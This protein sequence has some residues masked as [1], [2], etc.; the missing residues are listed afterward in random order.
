MTVDTGRGRLIGKKESSLT[1]D[2]IIGDRM[3]LTAQPSCPVTAN[4][5][6]RTWEKTCSWHAK[7][8]LFVSHPVV[9]DGTGPTAG[10][11][12][13]CA[14]GA[15]DVGPGLP[16]RGVSG[17]P[18]VSFPSHDTASALRPIQRSG[19]DERRVLAE[20]GGKHAADGAEPRGE[21]AGGGGGGSGR[22]GAIG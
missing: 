14:G 5:S 18:V 6:P 9:Y 7:H 2:K 21:E 10:S 1:Q 15:L 22:C 4:M 19:D 16:L 8:S 3:I 17:C 11:V 12:V 13:G 20:G